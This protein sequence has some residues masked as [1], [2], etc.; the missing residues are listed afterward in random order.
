MLTCAAES[1][2]RKHYAKSYCQKHYERWRRWGDPTVVKP[3]PYADWSNANPEQRRT[4]LLNKII[5]DQAT[6]CWVWQGTKSAAGY[7]QMV[8]VGS[9]KYTHRIA[10]EL[11][12]GPIPVGLEL[13][14]LCSNRDCCNPEHLEPV[15]HAVN[16]AR[17]ERP[18]KT[19]CVHGHSLSGY[20]LVITKYGHRLCRQ[21]GLDW[22]KRKRD[23]DRAAM[24][25]ETAL[26][27]IEA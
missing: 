2:D 13:D 8:V 25:G 20:N 27:Q 1:C 7:G 23:A 4:R 18:T 11:Y 17:G 5:H 21:C 6:G 26:P 24:R 12:V 16:V 22:H 10:Y 14:H 19:H 9:R 3:T 15:T